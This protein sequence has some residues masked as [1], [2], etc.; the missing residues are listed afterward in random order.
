MPHG[1]HLSSGQFQLLK[2]DKVNV[3]LGKNGCGKSSALRSIDSAFQGN[4]IRG[5]AKYITP[6]RGGSLRYDGNVETNVNANPNWLPN[7]RR[8]NRSDNFRQ[9][10]VGEFRRLETLVLRKIERD[11]EVRRDS[12]FTF[13]ATVNRINS[14]LDQVQIERGDDA[15]CRVA[16]AGRLTVPSRHGRGAALVATRRPCQRRELPQPHPRRRGGRRAQRG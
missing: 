16:R 4:A 6:E 13:D 1:L 3:I 9:V 5:M 15:G 10:S 8:V 14:L 7:T 12:S 11:P 2:L